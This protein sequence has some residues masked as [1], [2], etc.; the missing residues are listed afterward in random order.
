MLT[1]NVVESVIC[2]SFQH[3]NS[4]YLVMLVRLY[5]VFGSWLANYKSFSVDLSYRTFCCY[6][7]NVLM[8]K[9]EL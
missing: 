6:F 9:C 3:A 4:S 1:G 7:L 5:S 2:C 8:M